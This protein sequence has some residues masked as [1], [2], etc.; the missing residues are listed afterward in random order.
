MKQYCSTDVEAAVLAEIDN[1]QEIE[2]CRSKITC[3]DERVTARKAGGCYQ[4]YSYSTVDNTHRYLPSTKKSKQIERL[5]QGEYNEK[6]GKAVNERRKA[7]ERVL[8]I[9]Q[10]TDPNR[11]ILRIHPGKRKM[12]KEYLQDD[13]TFSSE[14]EQVEVNHKESPDRGLTTERGDV[15]RSKSEVLIANLLFSNNVPY[16]Y[17]AEYRF[18]D[19]IFYPDFTVLNARTR[20]EYIWEHLG[21]VANIDYAATAFSRLQRYQEQGL[22]IGKEIIITLE[23]QGKPLDT[24]KIQNIIDTYLK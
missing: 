16:R 7:L 14:W 24:K 2:A 1:L 22:I 8:R 6:L 10:K 13:N 9:I 18:P 20:K 11:V 17:E 15:V 19:G 12:I 5:C 21:M 3:G 4:F 23:S